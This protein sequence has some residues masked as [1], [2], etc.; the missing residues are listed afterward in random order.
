V[1]GPEPERAGRASALAAGKLQ[2]SRRRRAA[3]DHA[4]WRKPVHRR[5]VAV[6]LVALAVHGF[7][8]LSLAYLTACLYFNR[9]VVTVD[10]R[11]IRIWHGPIFWP[12]GLTLPADRLR[13]LF[14]REHLLRTKQ[15]VSRSYSLN[16]EVDGAGRVQCIGGL[17]TPEETLSFERRIEAALG[18]P[19]RRVRG[20]GRP[21]RSSP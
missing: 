20:E 19:D 15:G 7:V 6:T 2:G 16:A 9:T 11:E 14:C 1:P 3:R 4:I 21:R 10:R 5:L 8:V 17:S 13:Q 12:G 18:L